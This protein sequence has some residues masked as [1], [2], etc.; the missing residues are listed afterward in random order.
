VIAL[1]AGL[2]FAT[3]MI[4]GA[5]YALGQILVTPM[6]LLMS[7]LAAP[8]AAGLAMV[9]ERVLD[10]LLGA[11]IGIALAVACSSLDDRRHLAGHQMRRAAGTD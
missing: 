1:L 4:I 8:H 5:N 6:A 3:E 9:P 10:T 7:Y 2:Q 11:A